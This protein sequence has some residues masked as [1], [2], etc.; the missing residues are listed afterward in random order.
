VSA[1]AVRPAAASRGRARRAGAAGPGRNGRVRRWTGARLMAEAEIARKTAYAPY[2]RFHVGAA[3]LTRNGRVFH[4]CNVE[5][6]SFGLSACAE[7]TAVWK[8]VSEG[9]RDFVAI[10][11]TAGEAGGASPCGSC[12]QVMHEF[13]PR[14]LVYWRDG[15]GRIVRRRLGAL[16]E[17]AFDFKRKE[18][19]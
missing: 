5:N 10:A 8:A 16:L 11:V 7:R 13:A 4:G 15:S 12:R 19:K 2:S 18:S 14:M 6:A 3:L 9:V 17:R 1:R